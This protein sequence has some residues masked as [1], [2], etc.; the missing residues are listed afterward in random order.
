MFSGAEPL[1]N[2]GNGNMGNIRVKLCIYYVIVYS[3]CNVLKQKK[4]IY[5]IRST[6]SLENS[7]RI[8]L[9]ILLFQTQKTSTYL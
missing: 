8:V 3:V 7:S 2:F 9:L 1:C 4:Y 6:L 5:I